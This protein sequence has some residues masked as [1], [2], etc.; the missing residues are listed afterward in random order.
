MIGSVVVTCE[1]KAAITASLLDAIS[2]NSSIEL[3]QPIE[4]RV[5]VII[6]SSDP[7]GLESCTRWLMDIPGVAKVDVVFVHFEDEDQEVEPSASQ[8]LKESPVS[9]QSNLDGSL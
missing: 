5:P 9:F 2:A 6:D 1:S 7:D 4:N 3:G 8:A